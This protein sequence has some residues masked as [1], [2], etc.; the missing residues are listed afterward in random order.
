MRRT[1]LATV[2]ACGLATASSVL[3]ALGTSSDDHGW[4]LRTSRTGPRSQVPGPRP[5]PPFPAAFGFQGTAPQ[6]SSAQVFRT[7]VEIVRLD[8]R[9]TDADGVPIR[10]L[11]ADEIQVLESGD[12]RPIVLFQHVIQ[13]IGTYADVARRTIAS[14][15]STNQGAP[16]GNVYALVFDQGHITAGNE[17]R[18]RMAA[19]RFL[20]TRVKP[21][22]RVALYAVPGPGPQ[23]EFTADATRA[24]KE[25]VAVRG[26]R[27]DEQTG[28]LGSMRVYDAYE[29]TRGNQDVVTRYVNRLADN[30]TS[31]DQPATANRQTVRVETEDPSVTRRLVQEDARTIVSRADGDARRFLQD[32]TAIVRTLREVDGRKSVIL[33]SEG[34]AIDHVRQELEDVAAAAAQSYCLV[35]A[36]DLNSRAVDL[37]QATPRDSA[38]GTEIL[39]R[40]E[41]LG[42]LVAETDGE[43]FI[44]AGQRADAV[45]DRIAEAS[46]DYYVVG[47]EPSAAAIANRGQYRRVRVVTTR[48]G[49]LVSARTGYALAPPVVEADRRRAIEGA[50]RAPFSQQGLRVEY[51]TYVLRGSS[52]DMQRVILSLAAELPVSRP[53]APGADVVFSVRDVRDGRLAASGGDKLELP[54]AAAGG[55]TSGTGHYRVQFELPPGIYVMR[56]VVREPGGLLGS[57]DRRFQVRALGGP[58]VTAGDLIL[59]SA[60]TAGLPVRAT[61]YQTD[62]LAGLMEI[63][64]RSSA[65]LEAVAVDVE[66]LPFGSAA[67][68]RRG[69]ADLSAIVSGE[70]GASR[71]ARVELPLEGVPPGE[72]VVRATVRA[73]AETAAEVLRDVTIAPGAPPAA[74]VLPPASRPDVSTVLQGDAARQWIAALRARAPAHLKQAAASAGEADWPAVDRAVAAAG[75]EGSDAQALLGLAR[76]GQSDYRAAASALKVYTTSNPT[77]AVAAFVLGWAHVG[78]GDDRAAVAAFRSAVVGNPQFVPA[79]LAAIDTYVR[80]GQPALALQVARSGVTAIPGSTEIRDRLL[81]LEGRQ[82]TP[83]LGTEVK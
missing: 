33:F 61:A 50:L 12:E 70:A 80:M 77:D 72:Y 19:E 62:A 60:D 11:R 76:L 75:A 14:E 68:V 52:A 34:F 6:E 55:R 13:P 69:R 45:L 74:P 16:R 82:R 64:A 37:S 56:A 7:G 25:L 10:D 1:V 43:L 2:V 24:A 31:S 9:V 26:T 21:G 44:D 15:V 65:Q 17:Q 51:T 5:Q 42:S 35:Y 22:D 59:G 81:R 30:P 36:L 67:P 58:S 57:A 63:Y 66:L 47:F 8:V 83:R 46:Q 79:Y 49:A 27:Q 53:D 28:A 4:G 78:A 39:S 54:P 20:R 29:I 38:L 73:G 48:P 3:F 40:L 32:L 18:A 41:P 71:G 23:L